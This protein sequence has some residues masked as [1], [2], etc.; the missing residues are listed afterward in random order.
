[1]LGSPEPLAASVVPDCLFAAVAADV[2]ALGCLEEADA[3]VALGM[4]PLSEETELDASFKLLAA[5]NLL[6]YVW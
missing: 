5:L 2:T 4:S 6:L 1:M 3:A